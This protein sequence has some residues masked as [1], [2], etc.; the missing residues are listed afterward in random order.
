MRIATVFSGIGA[1]EQALRKLDIDHEIIFACDNGE[2]LLEKPYD[3]IVEELEALDEF[4]RRKHISE[5]YEMTGKPNYVRKT[6][7]ANYEI[8][9]HRWYEDIRFINGKQYENRVDIFVGGSPCQSFSA[10][11]KRTGLDDAR[12]TLFHDYARLIDEIKPKAFIFENVPGM[13]SHDRGRTWEIICNVFHELGYELHYDVLNSLDFGIPQRRKRLF[14]VGLRAQGTGFCMP[15]PLGELTTTMFDYLEKEIH[16]L[17]YLGQK[18][19]NFVTNPKYKN[20]ARVNSPIIRTQ[21]ANQQFNWNGD[22]VFEEESDIVHNELIKKR[23]YLGDYNN[24]RGYI[25]QLT[26]KECAKLMG[27]SN[28]FVIDAPTMHAYRQVGNSIVVNVLEAI[29]KE[30]LRVESFEEEN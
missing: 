5:L 16:H 17:H 13:L 23:G 7:F 19:F 11:G 10:M 29:V 18:G 21:K 6:Y 20:R 24:R 15:E 12:G 28:D 4:S 14:V 9:E 3:A 27:F 8:D 30:I 2:R 22:F 1:F 26:P 25:R